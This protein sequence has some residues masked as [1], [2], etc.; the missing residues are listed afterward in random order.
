MNIKITVNNHG[1]LNSATREQIHSSLGGIIGKQLAA[2][3]LPEI[4]RCAWSAVFPR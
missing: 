1:R 4:R 3:A 2:M